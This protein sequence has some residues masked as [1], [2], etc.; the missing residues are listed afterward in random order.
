MAQAIDE[1]EKWN[2]ITMYHMKTLSAN[3]RWS[4]CNVRHVK[5][6]I[7]NEKKLLSEKSLIEEIIA[8]EDYLLANCARPRLANLNLSAQIRSV[9]CVSPPDY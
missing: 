5:R 6:K 7:N 9:A 1:V 8:T 4:C 3:G 2:E